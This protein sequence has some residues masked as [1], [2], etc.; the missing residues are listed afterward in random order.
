MLPINTTDNDLVTGIKTT[1]TPRKG[2]TVSGYGG[3]VPT[4]YMI[5]Y[6]GLWHRV[7]MM[8][9]GNSGTAYIVKGGRDLLLDI[10]TE[11]DLMDHRNA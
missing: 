7:L 11:Y 10:Q 6:A 3:S 8:Q 4:P 5:Q 2:Q 1:E 9:Y